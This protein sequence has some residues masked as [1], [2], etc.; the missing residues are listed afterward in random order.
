MRVPSPLLILLSVIALTSCDDGVLTFP[1][2]APA[3]VRV[4]NV[5]QDVQVLSVLVN[6]ST[7]VSAQRGMVTDQTQSPA[8]R[9]VSFLLLEGAA[10]LRDTLFYTLGG[11]AT[12]ILFARG[13]KVNVVEFRR[14]IQDTAL[15]ADADPVIRF[16]HMAENVNQYVTLEVWLKGGS[17]LMSEDFDPGFTSTG[18]TTLSP[19]TYSFEVREYQTTNVAASLENVTL[20]RGKS[21][22]LYTW[23]A[24]P[25]TE[26]MLSLSIF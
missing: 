3:T 15:P 23:D 20:E 13:S 11:S 18:Y 6:G 5:T 25:P 12:V 16:T 26:D 7:T 1:D 19:G 8:G 4:V 14:A 2:P 17:R 10:P 22:M 24:Q 9:P 21:Y